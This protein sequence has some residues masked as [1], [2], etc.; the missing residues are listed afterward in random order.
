MTIGT[1]IRTRV[2]LNG[3]P[4]GTEGIVRSVWEPARG[5]SMDIETRV[6]DWVTLHTVWASEIEL[7]DA[8]AAS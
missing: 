7:V 1:R 3:V 2:A 6:G 8:T 5:I 4:V